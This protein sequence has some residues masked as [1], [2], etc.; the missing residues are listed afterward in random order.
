M[1]IDINSLFTHKVRSSG[2]FHTR[3]I[4]PRNRL[5]VSKTGA[6]L[7]CV[8]RGVISPSHVPRCWGW[9]SVSPCLLRA[10]SRAQAKPVTLSSPRFA[11]GIPDPAL[12]QWA[13]AAHAE[14]AQTQ[15]IHLTD[16]IASLRD[17]LHQYEHATHTMA[18]QH[19]IEVATSRTKL[20]KLQEQEQSSSRKTTAPTMM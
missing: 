10:R 5:L 11:T 7:A 15:N 1:G 12:A 8:V 9:P 18:L 6:I 19:Q 13:S 16:T 2:P 3:G 14:V 20:Q 17:N 4:E